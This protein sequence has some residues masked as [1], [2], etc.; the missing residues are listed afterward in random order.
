MALGPDFGSRAVLVFNDLRTYR[1]V[2][3]M[4]TTVRVLE[5]ELPSLS[6][7]EVA[8]K[9]QWSIQRTDTV[10]TSYPVPRT[11]T[12]DTTQVA[13]SRLEVCTVA[14]VV[15]VVTAVAAVKA[16]ASNGS[17]F[18]VTC[19]ENNA[20]DR[21]A[22]L[23]SKNN[24]RKSAGNG[25]RPDDGLGNHFIAF[26]AAYEGTSRNEGQ[27]AH[28]EDVAEAES[29]V[30]Y[31]ATKPSPI[32][33]NNKSTAVELSLQRTCTA[34]YLLPSYQKDQMYQTWRNRATRK[35]VHRRDVSDL[36]P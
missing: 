29:K 32:G 24:C 8:G 6:F 23:T 13:N 5:M 35:G 3:E 28:L 11:P 15:A 33:S 22:T 27:D 25:R 34:L 1:G 10:K 7:V 30:L 2:K 17:M 9:S 20:A 21:R 16:V 26:V 18:S 12:E 19:S 31:S 14:M 36:C 4:E